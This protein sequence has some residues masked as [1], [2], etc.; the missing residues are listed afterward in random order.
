MPKATR[1]K[2]LKAEDFRKTKLKVGKKL[3]PAANQTDASFKSQSIVV[4]NQSLG[5]VKSA[6]DLVNNRNQSFKD[7]IVQLRHYAAQ[8]RKDALTGLREIQ[9]KHAGAFKTQLSVIVA[10]TAPVMVDEEGDVRKTL[11]LFFQDFIPTVTKDHIRP[12]M[13]LIVAYTCSSMTHISEHIRLD[14]LKFLTVWQTHYPALLVTHAEKVIPNYLSMLATNS[15]AQGMGG[16]GTGSSLLVNPRSQLGGAK[17]RV[18]VLESLFGYLTLVLHKGSNA[19]W[20]FPGVDIQRGVSYNSPTASTVTCQQARQTGA[21]PNGASQLLRNEDRERLHNGGSFE[22]FGAAATSGVQ[23]DRVVIGSIGTGHKQIA[24]IRNTYQLAEFDQLQAFID[25][26]MPSLVDIWLESGPNALTPG[27]IALTPALSVMHTVLKMMNLMWRSILVEFKEKSL[28]NWATRWLKTI[29]K[30]FMIH[31]PFGSGNFTVRDKQVEVILQ[32]MNILFCELLSHFSLS[33]APSADE[34][35]AS[36]EAAMLDYLTELFAGKSAKS[37]MDNTVVILST[38]QFEATFP[39]VW[40]L[41]RTTSSEESSSFLRAFVE[42]G[43][44]MWGTPSAISSFEFVSRLLMLSNHREAAQRFAL[45][46]SSVDI[47]RQWVLLLP[48]RLWQLKSSNSVFSQHILEVL[49]YILRNNP[50]NFAV[51]KA[52]TNG[53]EASIVPFFHADTAKGSIFGPFLECP[54]TVQMAAVTLLYYLPSW[55]AKLV[56]GFAEVTTNVSVSSAVVCHA[57]GLLNHRQTRSS[58]PLPFDTYVSI[59]LTVGAVGWTS[60][61]L[62]GLVNE[63]QPASNQTCAVF[64]TDDILRYRLKKQGTHITAANY[65]KR[66]VQ[67]M[68]QLVACLGHQTELQAVLLQ[69]FSNLPGQLPLDA[70]YGIAQAV[71]AIDEKNTSE[72]DYTRGFLLDLANLL[73]AGVRT[74]YQSAANTEARKSAEYALEVAAALLRRD[75]GMR[76]AALLAILTHLNVSAEATELQIRSTHDI[77]STLKVATRLMLGTELLRNAVAEDEMCMQRLRE[78]ATTVENFM[79]QPTNAALRNQPLA[80][81]AGMLSRFFIS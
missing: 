32:D 10:A 41:L 4:P 69:G 72:R 25:V 76:R 36:N 74:C 71:L 43:N 7:M 39:V 44:M 23:S 3:A 16:A 15:K 28:A 6:S 12:F 58:L 31:F 54:E 21:V 67:I 20:F 59:L 38:Q 9:R 79:A 49:T 13:S 29:S 14:G 64:G 65:W 5:E 27:S 81:E 35:S 61:D 22:L 11:L 70:F 8:S 40:S 45:S 37:Q 57:L 24:A 78:I 17:A 1:R 80:E 30:H 77:L 62:A 55:P 33:V 75:V 47:L 68:S 18:E 34:S 48:K 2:K 19:W 60:A 46:A 56:R 52:V 51:D 66:R 50:C 42:R 63:A 53:L 26:L 73:V